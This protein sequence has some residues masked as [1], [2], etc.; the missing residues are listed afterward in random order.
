MQNQK[1]AQTTRRQAGES[2][3]EKILS[4]SGSTIIGWA[5][6][7]TVFS[8]T[9]LRSVDRINLLDHYGGSGTA[10]ENNAGFGPWF[11]VVLLSLVAGAGVGLL[12]WQL[13][14]RVDAWRFA[15]GD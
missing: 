5:S 13:A 1:A 11:V 8:V 7:A 2:L 12:L 3:I 4:G 6:G 9:M 15:A 14:D 10:I